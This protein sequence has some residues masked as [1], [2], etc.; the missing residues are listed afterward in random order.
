MVNINAKRRITS[1]LLLVR[2]PTESCECDS[3]RVLW[4]WSCGFQQCWRHYKNGLRRAV[5]FLR[6]L[7]DLEYLIVDLKFPEKYVAKLSGE[8]V[9]EEILGIFNVFDKIGGL[10]HM[11]FL[12]NGSCTST[13]G[14]KCSS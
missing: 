4:P 6:D 1:V 12:V 10:K 2:S 5:L 7:P 13:P 3:N 8:R 14:L 11:S 9:P